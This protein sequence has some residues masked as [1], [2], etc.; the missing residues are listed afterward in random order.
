MKDVTCVVTR[1]GR[2]MNKTYIALKL[3]NKDL[4]VQT[5]YFTDLFLKQDV[6]NPATQQKYTQDEINQLEVASLTAPDNGFIAISS[7][8]GTL[9]FD[10]A[11]SKTIVSHKDALM[12]KENEV[13]TQEGK[14]VAKA[15]SYLKDIP[16][17]KNNLTALHTT[18]E[19]LDEGIK[20]VKNEKIEED[21]TNSYVTI[22]DLKMKNGIIECDMKSQLL[23]DCWEAARG[24]IGIAFRIDDQDREFEGFYI[25]PTNGKGCTNE[26]RRAHGCQYF[27]Y[28]GYIWSYYREHGI[29]DFEAPVETIA[30][31]EWAHVKVELIDDHARFWVNNELVL[32]VNKLQHTPQAGR[33]GFN[34]H[35]DSQC[36]FKNLKVEVFD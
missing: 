3:E 28:P 27:A 15:I 21:D 10:E 5:I 31:D 8:E 13:L 20:S 26:F 32:E 23:P 25:R 17:T 35:I 6:I 34:T 9:W 14:V 1:G 4:N 16:L 11:S 12:I 24:F 22:N 33:I 30:L 29:N 19:I 36:Y 2:T 7:Y 18:L